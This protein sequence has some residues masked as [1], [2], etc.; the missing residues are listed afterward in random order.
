MITV[1][2]KD[3]RFYAHHGITEDERKTG[4]E[5]LVNLEVLYDS[6]ESEFEN[7]DDVVNYEV[8]FDIVRKRMMVATPL[9][10]KICKSIIRKIHHKFSSVQEIR[11]SIHKLQ[12]P[13]PY[14][15]GTVGVKMVRQFNKPE[16][17]RKRKK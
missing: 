13:I 17:D 6:N 16:K 3:L 10:E 1:E 5:Y 9:L 7:L 12:A 4:N 2:L 8:L 15:D 11:L 14:L